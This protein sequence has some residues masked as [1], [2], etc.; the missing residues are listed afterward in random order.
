MDRQ[1]LVATTNP[2]KIE[3]LSELL[4]LDARFLSLGDVGSI[5]EVVEAMRRFV[6]VPPWLISSWANLF[7]ILLGGQRSS[8]T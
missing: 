2:G 3:E 1:I 4:D 7:G 5:P 8:V 6:V